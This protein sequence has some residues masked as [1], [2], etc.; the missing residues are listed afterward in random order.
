MNIWKFLKF[1]KIKL[2]LKIINSYKNFYKNQENTRMIEF[3]LMVNKQ[4][5]TRFPSNSFF[6]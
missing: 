5:Q 1:V 6:I 2:K 4:G 3:I